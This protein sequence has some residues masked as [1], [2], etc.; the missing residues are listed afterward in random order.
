MVFAT[1]GICQ[2]AEPQ[3]WR[4]H[5]FGLSPLRWAALARKRFWVMGAGTGFGQAIAIALALSGARVFLSG[6][7]APKLLETRDRAI[8]FGAAAD[9]CVPLPCDAAEEAQLTA[10]VAE[11]ASHGGS[12]H[13]LVY[14]SA[15]PSAGFAWPLEQLPLARWDAMMRT[16][17]TG[18]WLTSRAAIPLMLRSGGARVVLLSSEAGWT[19]T[20]GFGPYNISKAA[21]NNLGM[22]LAEEYTGSHSEGDIQ[23]NVLVPGEARTEMNH[24]STDSP[25]TAA[26]MTLLLLSQPEG[27]PN[28][29]FFHRDGRHL[30]FGH[31]L[32]YERPLRD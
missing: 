23:V 5:H 1:P 28:G 8:A 24:G 10:A 3:N 29:C 12:L 20:V 25:F 22:S 21:L 6:R 30:T 27:G 2:G 18:A 15:L 14:C 19:G 9:R 16:N 13:G 31:R 11:I 7:R 32:A 17:V 26:P 4:E